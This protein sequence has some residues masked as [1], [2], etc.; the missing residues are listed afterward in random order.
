MTMTLPEL[1]GTPRVIE[2]PVSEGMLRIFVTETISTWPWEMPKV[3]I[4]TT[5]GRTIVLKRLD[6]ES[7][8]NGYPVLENP[9]GTLILRLMNGEVGDFVSCWPILV[10]WSVMA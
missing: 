1:L 9:E 5:N 8:I 4:S 7:R 2:E 3:R 6:E 10:H